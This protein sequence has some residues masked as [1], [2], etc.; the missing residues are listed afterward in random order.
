ME[1]AGIEPSGIDAIFITHEHADHICGLEYFVRRFKTKVY[2]HKDC[3]A[4]FQNLPNECVNIFCGG[5]QIGDILVE[6][7]PVPHDSQFCFGYTFKCGSEKIGIATDL[8]RTSPEIIAALAG[9]QI[10]FIESNHDLLRLT[11]NKKYP[12]LLKRRIT[13][14]RGHLSNPAASMAI[15]QLC[16][17]GV[18]QFILAHLSEQNNSP[19]IA[20]ECVRDFLASQGITEGREVW[21]DVAE[22][23]KVG[24]KFAVK[25]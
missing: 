2:I 14:S 1:T 18:S 22:Q 25:G 5:V 19:T 23:D 11:S 13:S 17:T 9:S 10:V 24:Q 16:K 20:F 21:I 6:H 8:G 12:L 15:Y 3:V 4:L 7:F